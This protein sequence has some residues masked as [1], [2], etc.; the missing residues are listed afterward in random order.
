M[1]KTIFEAETDTAK[2][3]VATYPGAATT[4][5]IFGIKRKRKRKT[6]RTWLGRACALFKSPSLEP[7]FQQG[8]YK[9]GKQ[10]AVRDRQGHRGPGGL[11]SVREGPKDCQG[12]LWVHVL[13]SKCAPS[14]EAD[15]ESPKT[16]EEE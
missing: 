4:V 13:G 6:T 11:G 2:G 16:E 14:E 15:E 8:D 9:K 7:R 5:E 10:R 1:K 3:K 12:D